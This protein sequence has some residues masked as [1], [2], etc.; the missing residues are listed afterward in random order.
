M[1]TALR[2]LE[3]GGWILLGGLAALGGVLIAPAVDMP[4]VIMGA[5]TTL[6]AAGL[7]VLGNWWAR[8]RGFLPWAEAEARRYQTALQDLQER[9]QALQKG[10]QRLKQAALQLRERHLETVNQMAAERERAEQVLKQARYWETEAHAYQQRAQDLERQVQSLQRELRRAQRIQAL[11]EAVQRLKFGEQAPS[12]KPPSPDD[13]LPEDVPQQVRDLITHLQQERDDALQAAR[14]AEDAL[15]H[16]QAL[17]AVQT[18]KIAACRARLQDLQIQLRSAQLRWHQLLNDL[19]DPDTDILAVPLER[20]EAIQPYHDRSRAWST[21]LEMLRH[22]EARAA[23]VRT[24]PNGASIYPATES[25][26]RVLFFEQPL[27]KRLLWACVLWEAADQKQ[28]FDDLIAR[29]QSRDD[30]PEPRSFVYWAPAPRTLET[31]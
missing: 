25:P 24:L 3:W 5:L 16:K 6:A 26:R 14:V 19:L 31:P 23:H 11:T 17:L 1:R 12:L 30:C 21:L 8:R 18:A 28:D 9:H 27:N 7:V 4:G 15:Q 20:W 22:P 2:T 10:Y 13:S 29:V